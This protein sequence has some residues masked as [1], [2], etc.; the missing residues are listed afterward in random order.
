MEVQHIMYGRATVFFITVVITTI[1][2]MDHFRVDAYVMD[3]LM[4]DLVLHDHRPSAFLVYLHLW[5]RAAGRRAAVRA[6]HADIVNATG[7]SKRSVQ[8]AVRPLVPGGHRPRDV[9]DGVRG[10]DRPRRDGAV[11][12]N[13]S[14][15]IQGQGRRRRRVQ[16]DQQRPGHRAEG[17]AGR[18]L[19]VIAATVPERDRAHRRA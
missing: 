2:S 7:L 19:R 1:V 17:P 10:Q 12:R 8:G 15:G 11:G 6:S 5:Y 14:E 4:P 16:E 3:T 9:R 13:R 18:T